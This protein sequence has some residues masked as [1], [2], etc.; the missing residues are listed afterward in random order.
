MATKTTLK[1]L[2]SELTHRAE[3]VVPKG[4]LLDPLP[5]PFT[6]CHT[7]DEEQV[8]ERRCWREEEGLLGV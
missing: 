2:T 7:I 4:L 3:E 6:P 5:F 8:G 1:T